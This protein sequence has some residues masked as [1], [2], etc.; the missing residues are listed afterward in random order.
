MGAFRTDWDTAPN[1]TYDVWTT[2]NGGEVVPGVLT[3]F[4]ATMFSKLDHDTI[5]ELL[6]PYPT[7]KRIRCTS[8]PW[9]T[10]SASPPGG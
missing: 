8:R 1:P 7:S 6:E 9:P 4:S 5:R 3:P 2:T 10:S